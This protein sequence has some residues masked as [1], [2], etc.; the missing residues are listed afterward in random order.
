MLWG[1]L[2]VAIGLLF[3]ADTVG[4]LPVPAW[5]LAFPVVLLTLGVGAIIG[6][7]RKDSRTTQTLALPLSG[8]RSVRL[9]VGFG[10]GR[11]RISDGAPAGSAA[12]GT[13]AGGIEH[14]ERR[15]GDGLVVDLRIPNP[16]TAFI[17]PGPYSPFE[18]DVRLAAGV[19]TALDLDVG[20]AETTVDL[21]RLLVTEL[22][23]TTGASGTTVVL[24]QAA[25]STTVKV[26]AGAA[27]VDLTVPAGVA[28]RI[29]GTAGLGTII[30]AEHRFAKTGDA[31]E[32][33]DYRTAV[34]R[35]EISAEVG[36]GAVKVL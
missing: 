13:F 16:V 33:A 12:A 34:N 8:A 4:L 17:P 9:H 20:A 5:Q 36:V 29:T 2:L 6:G 10:G 23:I 19:P 25:G 21:A 32:S 11:L 15:S 31:W 26:N 22:T 24:P 3:L 35:V 28:A 30:V 1:I 14:S 27:S 18:W 7:L